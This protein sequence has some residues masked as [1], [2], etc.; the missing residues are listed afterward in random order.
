MWFGLNY[1]RY[2]RPFYLKGGLPLWRDITKW[3]RV[4]LFTIKSDLCYRKWRMRIVI[5]DNHSY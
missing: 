3:Q 2:K 4:G 5:I 1:I